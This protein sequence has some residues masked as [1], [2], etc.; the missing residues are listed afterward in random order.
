MTVYHHL[1]H[2]LRIMAIEPDFKKWGP[3]IDA[4]TPEQ[5]DECRVW[6]RQEAAMSKSRARA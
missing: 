1:T 6:L 4:L 5:Q 3:L 2:A